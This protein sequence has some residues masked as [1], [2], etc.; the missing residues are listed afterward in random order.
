MELLASNHCSR[1][2]NVPFLNTHSAISTSRSHNYSVV[3]GGIIGFGCSRSANRFCASIKVSARRNP[4]RKWR[5]G[6][7]EKNSVSL[8]DSTGPESRFGNE[9]DGGSDDSTFVAGEDVKG[10]VGVAS[11]SSVLQACIVTSGL[12]AAL[13]F[14]IRQV[15]HAASS[16]GLPILDCGELVSFNFEIW[17]IEL[18]SGLVLLISSSRYLLLKTWPD[19]AESSKAVNRQVLTSLETFDYLAVAFIPGIAEEL[20]FRGAL[21]PLFGHDWKSALAVGAA[22]GILHLGNGR[23]YSFAIWATFVGFAY[24]YAAIISSSVIVPMLVLYQL[25][26]SSLQETS[27]ELLDS[28]CQWYNVA[29]YA[30]HRVL[31]KQTILAVVNEMLRL[32]FLDTPLTI[33]GKADAV[34]DQFQC[35]DRQLKA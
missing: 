25:L 1:N 35:F 15:S 10:L 6:K 34:L 9:V 22:F 14:A 26:Y 4:G 28:N 8:M 20:L 2:P 5:G 33:N 23:N 27:A 21:L 29:V 17:H 7:E 12:I 19:F 13:G 3:H 11:R 24:G 31:L 16:G 18:I 32:K 30:S